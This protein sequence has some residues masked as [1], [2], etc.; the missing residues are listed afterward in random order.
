MDQ[1]L[2]SLDRVYASPQAPTATG[3]DDARTAARAAMLASSRAA[4]SRGV[5]LFL[6][7]ILVF[8]ISLPVGVV[9]GGSAGAIVALGAAGLGMVAAGHF[10]VALERGAVASAGVGAAVGSLALTLSS[11]FMTLLGAGWAWL[12]TM[13]FTRGRQIRSLGAI[14]LPPVE[15]GEAWTQLARG[16]E[17]ALEPA[18]LAEAASTRAALAAQWRENGRTE[19]ASVAAF[20]K[21]TLD[22]VALGAPPD[23][24]AAANRDAL[25]EIR[26]AEL[27]FGLARAL[28]GKAESP[29]AF[30]QAKTGRTLPRT[31]TMALAELAVDS[32]VDGALHEGISA[33]IVAKLARRCADPKIASM[34]KEIAADEGRHARHGWDVV[35]WC[36]AEGGV[37][38]AKALAGA[39]SS[40]PAKMSSPM[41]AEARDGRWERFGIMGEALEEE[42]HRAARADLERRV[43]DLVAPQ[44]LALG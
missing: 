43:R 32:L 7:S 13:T 28:D 31:R 6:G 4:R 22:L 35:R 9:A 44:V 17:L 19:H 2:S 16:G 20:A 38:V 23:L 30:A 34:M 10:L 36:L 14:H 21:L 39:L 1:P 40:L 42:E 3:E 18:T 26:H 37:P 33:R 11:L 12:S 5:R 29:G 24:V 41:P 15:E 8:A 27:C 25:D